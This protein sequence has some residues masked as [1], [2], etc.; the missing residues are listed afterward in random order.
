MLVIIDTDMPSGLYFK[1]T[2]FGVGS[3]GD[4]T[5]TAKMS[6]TLGEKLRQARQER[7]ISISEVAEQTR[8]STIYLESIESDNYKPLPGGI[9][10]KGFVKSYAK[11][12]GI[13]E[14]EAL[15]DYAKIVAET[16]GRDADPLRK[17]Q[18]EVLTD[19]RSSPSMAP[20][21]IFA[22]IILALGS[23]AIL[24]VL[25]YLQGSPS[26]PAP[27]DTAANTADANENEVKDAA[28][29]PS[30]ETIRLEFRALSE[31]VSISTTVDGKA[32]SDTVTLSEP[33]V[34]EARESVRVGFYRGFQAKVEL[35]LNGKKLEPPE[36]P[37]KGNAIV[38]EINRENVERVWQRGKIGED[39]AVPAPSPTVAAT[40]PVQTARP[41]PS[42]TAEPKETPTQTQTPAA[43]PA[44][45]RTAT[46]TPTPT[47]K[48]PASPPPVA[49]PLRDGS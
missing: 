15:Q 41:S 28:A 11:F 13:D 40:P 44:P 17:Y 3:S 46:P 33:R 39:P 31:P 43:T 35:T 34:L 22:V 21:I 2:D 45:L 26:D 30:F 7:G 19:D 20:Q 6:Q 47:A 25:N 49:T 18:P 9:F 12:I 5:T 48:P 23:A 4:T 27:T 36:P 10:N 14:H 24:L 29:T 37:A 38:F 32:S 8:I 16:E 1:F 42:P